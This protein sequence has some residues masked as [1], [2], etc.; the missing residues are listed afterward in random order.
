MGLSRACVST[1]GAFH[2]SMVHCFVYVSFYDVNINL[3]YVHTPART[4]I[5]SH[6]KLIVAGYV[7]TLKKRMHSEAYVRWYVS[8]FLRNC[9]YFWTN[10]IV[11]SLL[12]GL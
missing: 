7:M 9:Y 12:W 11:I 8:A 6:K 10:M 2:A 1:Y 3:I 5:I 4:L